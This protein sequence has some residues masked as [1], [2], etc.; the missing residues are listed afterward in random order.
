MSRACGPWLYLT[1]GGVDVGKGG[2]DAGVMF[3]GVVFGC[4]CCFMILEGGRGCGGCLWKLRV[5]PLWSFLAVPEEPR[6]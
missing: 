3:W 6:A 1:F 2:S 4:V 5:R